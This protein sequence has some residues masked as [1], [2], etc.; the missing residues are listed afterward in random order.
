[1][2][3]K[4]DGKKR[5]GTLDFSFEK[6]G[7]NEKSIKDDRSIPNELYQN[8]FR[9]I[10]RLGNK[11]FIVNKFSDNKTYF[12]KEVDNS[13]KEKILFT[14]N[15]KKII[16]FPNLNV[17][18]IEI[19]SKNKL[20]KIVTNL[21]LISDVVYSDFKFSDFFGDE[22][23]MMYDQKKL[24]LATLFK[25]LVGSKSFGK[26]NY[27]FDWKSKSP[28]YSV[29]DESYICDYKK[30]TYN[31]HIIPMVCT[32]D[33]QLSWEQYFKTFRKN[34]I[35]NV[36]NKW[37]SRIKNEKELEYSEILLKRIKKI[38]KEIDLI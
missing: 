29:N 2:K 21:W 30:R 37:K 1:M 11:S 13:I 12:I 24:I 35:I 10:K 4:E 38:K 14:E 36:L 26:E 6:N 25:S 28:I 5:E 3:E 8:N 16:N 18:L 7:R 20:N 31:I 9:N 19:N 32:D 22:R 34:D 23:N 33:I 17:N 27:L 15:L